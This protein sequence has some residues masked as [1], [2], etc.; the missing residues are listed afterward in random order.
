MTPS[1][2]YSTHRRKSQYCLR[3]LV[4][5]LTVV[6]VIFVPS[7]ASATSTQSFYFEDFTADYYLSR[8]ADGTSRMRVEEQLTAIFPDSDQNHGITRII[9]FTNNDGKNITMAS[10]SHF[11]IEVLRNG[12][13][14]PVKDIISENGYFEVRIGDTN[15]YVHGRQVY[16]LSYEFE[17]LILD[18][19][20]DNG[21]SW[22]ELYWDINGNDWSQRFN[23]VTARIHLADDIASNFTSE[24]A[25]YV[26]RYG[27]SGT[28]RCEAAR[29]NNTITFTT[30]KVYANE[31]LTIAMSFDAGTFTIRA[32]EASY[33][34]VIILAILL[35]LGIALI[36]LLIL[37]SRRVKTKRD[38]YRGLFVKPEYTAPR[39]FTVAE[40]A[41]N[42]I[43]KGIK[44]N[45]KVATLLELAVNHKIELVK[46]ETTGVFGKKKTGW[47]IRVKTTRDLSPEQIT[48]LKI[49]NGSDSSVANGQEIDIKS[50]TATSTLQRLA[51]EFSAKTQDSLRKKGLY[52]AKTAKPKGLCTAAVVTV[53]GVAW[54]F[55]AI[56]AFIASLVIPEESYLTYAGADWIPFLIFFVSFVI[57]FI[58]IIGA[59]KINNFEERTE[60]G[61]DYSC[62][63]DGLKL[64]VG[65]AEA[66][67]LKFLQ[68]V[69]GADT[70]HTGV[71][72][73]YEKLLP[74]AALLGL[75]KSW[76]DELSRYYEFS[77]VPTPTW[78]VGIGVF[79][80]RDF[81]NAMHALTSTA[82]TTI[83]HSTT[84]NSSSSGSGFSG[85]FSGGGGGGGG[86][87][88]W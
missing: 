6:S 24:V 32:P 58:I 1:F 20:D 18:Q 74:Y 36:V 82:G 15:E 45:P 63:L 79:S 67:R 4:S 17:N 56:A 29:D 8:D 27:E 86:G 70:S 66:D 80:A 41:E 54:F 62:Y 19:M 2:H 28:S 61:L 25:C 85:G 3:F 22:Q 55:M 30:A 88:G 43:G 11:N 64:Y 14:E 10:T 84:V 68:S 9:P 60:K 49:L 39:G 69:K 50:R 65:M 71:V 38:Y 13:K 72:K 75:E 76:L 35:I 87:G 57:L 81:S 48:V 12:K 33:L 44:G 16:T 26:G 53:L 51:Q 37:T 5:I 59:V 42:H 7:S 23:R 21:E 34:L 73:L 78:Y 31:S 40:M 47:Q 52:V 77:D 46:T 83:T